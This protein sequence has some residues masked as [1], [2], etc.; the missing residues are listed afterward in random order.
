MRPTDTIHVCVLAG[1]GK[2]DTAEF[3]HEY[4]VAIRRASKSLS[5][6]LDSVKP[7]TASAGQTDPRSLEECFELFSSVQ[8]LGSDGYYCSTCNEGE[9]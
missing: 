6:G 1:V 8:E 5:E 4:R 7:T 9:H 2:R 3:G